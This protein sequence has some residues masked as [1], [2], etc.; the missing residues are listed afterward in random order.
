MHLVSSTV[1]VGF[2]VRPSGWR[3][4]EVS[5]NDVCD[6]LS[7]FPSREIIHKIFEECGATETVVVAVKEDTYISKEVGLYRPVYPYTSYLLYDKPSR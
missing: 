4:L 3:S 1:L 2:T 6:R 7:A 5:F